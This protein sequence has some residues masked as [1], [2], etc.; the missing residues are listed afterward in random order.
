MGSDTPTAAH[1]PDSS[2]LF[3]DEQ[4]RQGPTESPRTARSPAPPSHTLLPPADVAMADGLTYRRSRSASSPGTRKRKSATPQHYGCLVESPSEDNQ[5]GRV[6]SQEDQSPDVQPTLLPPTQVILDTWV[7]QPTQP[8]RRQRS[9]APGHASSDA[10]GLQGAQQLGFAVPQIQTHMAVQMQ[11]A[12]EA[13][14]GAA[15]AGSSRAANGAAPAAPLLDIQC[16]I[17]MAS[18]NASTPVGSPAA[19][20]AAGAADAALSLA[21]GLRALL[22]WPAGAAHSN[23]GAVS[24]DAGPLLGKRSLAEDTY[25]DDDSFAAVTALLGSQETSHGSL[26]RRTGALTVA[27]SGNSRRTPTAAAGTSMCTSGG[28]GQETSPR[29]TAAAAPDG[30][31]RPSQEGAADPPAVADATRAGPHTKK[32]RGAVAGPVQGNPHMLQYESPARQDANQQQPLGNNTQGLGTAVASAP[33]D[34]AGALQ[35]WRSLPSSRL[36]SEGHAQ[37]LVSAGVDLLLVE[38]ILTQVGSSR[39]TFA[40]VHSSAWE[41]S[42]WQG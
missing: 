18:R 26:I 42:R 10:Q 21:G 32:A 23:S 7:C 34:A 36:L 8:L 20:V 3:I 33:A 29:S 24:A 19:Q 15:G 25:G 22:G 28:A 14:P 41:R 31:R 37:A 9:S 30:V 40:H 4:G 39:T 27:T 13:E 38:D 5:P 35:A 12:A 1:K 2:F 16:A 6:L 11:A 17:D